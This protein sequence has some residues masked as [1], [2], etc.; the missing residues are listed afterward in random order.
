MERSEQTIMQVALTNAFEEYAMGRRSKESIVLR[1]WQTAVHQ[2]LLSIGYPC[3]RNC[4]LSYTTQ[5]Q[6]IKLRDK[7]WSFENFSEMFEEIRAKM[8]T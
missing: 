2:A 3:N 5:E 7:A 4:F 1:H 8:M 6:K